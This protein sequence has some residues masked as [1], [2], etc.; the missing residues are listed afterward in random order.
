MPSSTA[1]GAQRSVPESLA[2][3]APS[4]GP[5]Q[6][7]RVRV[8]RPG[9]QLVVLRVT[10]ALDAAGE[11]RLAE[12]LRHRLNCVATTV[13]LDMSAVTFLDTA[14]AV[15]LLEAACRAEATGKELVVISSPAVDRLL[16]LLGLTERFT[17][18]ASLAA[19]RA[20]ATDPE[21]PSREPGTDR[22]VAVRVPPQGTGR[23]STSRS[24]PVR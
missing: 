7:L 22:A 11:P 6:P 4:A 15:T 24:S 17:Y 8:C 12:P 3:H 2:E 10:G 19:L 9:A 21:P 5:D 1:A 20:E 23:T 18:A 14:G 16:G 13:V